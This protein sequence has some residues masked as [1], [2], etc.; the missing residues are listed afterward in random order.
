ML[1]LS[2]IKRF[3]RNISTIY[4]RYNSDANI[5]VVGKRDFGV[6]DIISSRV[7]WIQQVRKRTNNMILTATDMKIIILIL[8]AKK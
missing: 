5:N 7:V 3:L 2:N 8:Y 4:V 6:S 1:D